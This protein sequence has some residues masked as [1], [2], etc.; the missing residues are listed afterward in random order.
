[1]FSAMISLITVPLSLSLY[2][3][4]VV[5]SSSPTPAEMTLLV[6]QGCL[7]RPGVLVCKVRIVTN[8]PRRDIPRVGTYCS[9]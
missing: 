3:L 1:M 7:A 4:V 6:S 8:I 2:P 5:L 9:V